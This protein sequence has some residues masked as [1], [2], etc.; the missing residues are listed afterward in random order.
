M[1]TK[2]NKPYIFHID[3]DSYFVSAIRTVRTDLK[4]TP[5]AIGKPNYKSIATSVSYDLRSKG[6]KAGM[7]RFEI[8][9]IEPKTVF[10]EANFELFTQ[11][12]TNIFDYLEMHYASIINVASIDEC[13]IELRQNILDDHHAIQIARKIQKEILAKFDI[14]ITIGISYKPFFAKMTTNI[15]KPFGVGLTNEINYKEHFFNLPISDFHGIGKASSSKLKKLGIFKIQDLVEK[16][17]NDYVF[18]SVFGIVYKTWLKNI[19]PSIYEHLMPQN[20]IPKG[21]GN[22]ITFDRENLSEINLYD[23]LIEISKKVSFRAKRQGMVGNVITLCVRFDNKKW[24]LKNHKID[25]YTNEY[26]KIFQIAK[27]LFDKYYLESNIIGLGIR[28]SNLI[29]YFNNQESIE[30]FS[31]HSSENASNMAINRIISQ[32]NRQMKKPLL[33]TLKNIQERQN[34]KARVNKYAL[35]G[36]VFK[37][38]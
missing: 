12:S 29:F 4:N 28:L 19:D 17:I 18:Q 31:S 30:L 2:I 1:H 13:Y 35:E 23:S 22:E 15:S 36:F 38:R 9:K 24:V 32:V 27:Y 16:P 6:A 20:N 25:H 5:L 11:I 33:R 8:L 34:I 14:P 10:V 3:F 7:N 21:I 37:K 26:Q